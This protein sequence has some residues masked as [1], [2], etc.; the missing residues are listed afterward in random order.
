MYEFLDPWWRWSTITNDSLS[1]SLDQITFYEAFIPF[2]SVSIEKN[3]RSE[4]DRVGLLKIR[5]TDFSERGHENFPWFLLTTSRASREVHGSVGNLVTSS[6]ASQT[7]KRVDSVSSMPFSFFDRLAENAIW[8]LKLIQSLYYIT[9][10]CPVPTRRQMI[11]FEW[12]HE[13]ISELCHENILIW[14]CN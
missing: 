9:M 13:L 3:W 10:Y 7:L 6:I 4:T 14:S 5:L 1:K 11:C 12:L 2:E 8:L